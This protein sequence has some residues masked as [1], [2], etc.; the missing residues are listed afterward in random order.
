[1]QALLFSWL[2]YLVGS[3]FIERKVRRILF[4][5]AAFL[6]LVLYSATIYF[7][8]DKPYLDVLLVVYFMFIFLHFPTKYKPFFVVVYI[9]IGAGFVLS[10]VYF[11]DYSKYF[12]PLSGLM[13]VFRFYRSKG[14]FFVWGLLSI[15]ASL[16]YLIDRELF[17]Y[18]NIPFVF[19]FVKESINSLFEQL[20]KEKRRYRDFVDRA[21]SSEIQKQYSELDDELKITYKKLK[22]IFKLSNDTL[23]PL[24]IEDIAERVVEGLHNLGYSGVILYVNT[25][26]FNAFK[27]SGFFPYMKNYLE[28]RFESIEKITISDDEKQIFLPL[29][30]DKGKI[31]VLAVYKKEGISPKEIEYL[32]TYANSV[33]ISITKTIYFKEINKLQE[34][35]EKTFE[36]VDI[37]IAI[38]DKSYRI[39]RANRALKEITGYELDGTIFEAIP[40]IEPLKRELEAVIKDRKVVDTLLSSIHRKGSIYRVKA[41]P[42]ISTDRDDVDKMVLVIEDVTEKEKLEAQLIETEK[43]AVIGKMVAGLSHDIKN[44]LAAISASAFAI[45]RRGNRLKDGRI[46]ELAEKIE[47]NSTRAADIINKL[48]NFAKPSYYKMENVNLKEVILSSI[49]FAIP[50]KK[51]KDIKV[52]RR[53][54]SDV[55]T[56]GDK[57]ALQQVFINIL[58]NAVEALEDHKGVIEIKL[59][60]DRENAVIS[61]KDNGVGI[62]KDVIDEV[63]DP[64][65]TTKEKGTGLGL[66]VVKKIIK[67]HN[68]DI[69]VYSREGEG[70]EFIIKLPLSEEE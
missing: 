63:F 11:P 1:M 26:S 62:P 44:P 33:A 20:E 53:L 32:S 45:K 58:I 50:E 29:K 67:D 49:E 5:T 46:I 38:V 35:L 52:Y 10:T 43:H 31:G 66:S 23:S 48:L 6:T 64:F 60:K 70:T 59:T 41:L 69:E 54:R 51:K 57:N 65:F 4:L 21:I 8:G 39:E 25:G 3:Y 16:S 7:A 30:S 12:V 34:L 14:D 13:L 19:Y 42:L 15:V 9:L 17:F 36:S 2:T 56:Y 18:A 40:E 37:G 22:V 68:G 47:K 28:D 24:E 55:Y 61:I 27:K